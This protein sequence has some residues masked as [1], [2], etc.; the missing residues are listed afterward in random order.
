MRAVKCRG[1]VPSQHGWVSV[2]LTA[3]SWEGKINGKGKPSLTEPA[4][5]L[6]MSCFEGCVLEWF[7]KGRLFGIEYLSK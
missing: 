6:F 7:E 1:Y 3:E 2:C 4:L 5:Y